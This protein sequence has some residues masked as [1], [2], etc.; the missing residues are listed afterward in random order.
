MALVLL[1]NHFCTNVSL[2][3]LQRNLEIPLDG[4]TQK[5]FVIIIIIVYTC[6]RYECKHESDTTPKSAQRPNGKSWTNSKRNDFV[7]FSFCFSSSAVLPAPTEIVDIQTKP[8]Y[9]FIYFFV[10]TAGQWLPSVRSFVSFPH[11]I[12]NFIFDSTEHKQYE[13][14]K[15]V[16]VNW[17]D[18]TETKWHKNITHTCVLYNAPSPSRAIGQHTHERTNVHMSIYSN[19]FSW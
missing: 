13:K 11:E 6:V 12:W 18:V 4:Q 8:F 14:S 9:L 3:S 1:F 5:N 19:L 15:M 7:W 10:K 17:R 2:H 16:N